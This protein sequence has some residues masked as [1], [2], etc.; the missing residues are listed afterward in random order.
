MPS[1]TAGA[2][3]ECLT[4]KLRAR[5]AEGDHRDYR[6]FDDQGVLVA[7]TKLSHSWRGTTTI[8]A[9]MV[10]RI[11]SQLQVPRTRDLVDLVSCAL[12]RDDYLA[13]AKRP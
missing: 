12:S 8:S 5:R 10:S 13:L 9:G 2:L 7:R 4:G 11:A 1:L 3:D 6:V